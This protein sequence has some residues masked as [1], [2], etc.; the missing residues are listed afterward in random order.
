[1]NFRLDALDYPDEPVVECRP[2]LLD[3]D[4]FARDLQIVGRVAASYAGTRSQLRVDVRMLVTREGEVAYA[5]VSRSS[6]M[7][8]L[9]REVLALAEGL[10]FHP[11]AVDDVPV[12]VWVEQPVLVQIPRA[13]DEQRRWPE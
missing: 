12:D 2:A 4:R 7:S 5:E 13:Q 11:A 9:D 1:M 3:P 6:S 8:A 10:R